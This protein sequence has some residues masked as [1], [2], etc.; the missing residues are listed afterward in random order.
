MKRAEK[1][2]FWVDEKKLQNS[3]YWFAHKNGNISVCAGAVLGE[4]GE[5]LIADGPEVGFF[6]G[7]GQARAELHL[8]SAVIDL[9]LAVLEQV[10]VP[11]GI[12]VGAA[13]R[14]D[15]EETILVGDVHQGDGAQTAALGSL[16]GHKTDLFIQI[17]VEPAPSSEA[18]QESVQG[19][20]DPEQPRGNG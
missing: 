9:N 6:F 19:C 17:R 5:V 20:H 8:L 4:G 14:G 7:R 3:A 18:V 11:V 16:H 10:V 2:H 1:C 15:E 13:T 12:L